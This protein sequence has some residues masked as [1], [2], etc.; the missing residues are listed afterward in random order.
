M[1]QPVDAF[2]ERIPKPFVFALGIALVMTIG[3]IDLLSAPARHFAFLYLGPIALVSWY[4]GG[5]AGSGIALLS[6]L[7]GFL[8]AFT[9]RGIPGSWEELLVSGGVFFLE[10]IAVAQLR[11]KL[12]NL[13]RMATLDALTGLPNA[14]AFFE[15]MTRQTQQCRGQNPLTLVYV[16]LGGVDRVNRSL[17]HAAGDQLLCTMAQVIKQN[18]PRPELIGRVGGTTF[19]LLLPNAGAES[20]KATVRQLQT[21]LYEARRKS[22]LAITFSISAMTCTEAPPSVAGLM[23][24]AESRLRRS[25]ARH[26][27][28]LNIVQID[29]FSALH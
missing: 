29:S 7:Y 8:P 19:A 28:A 11:R 4:V 3:G 1:M 2:L 25:K 24:E 21:R 9:S 13:S 6:L 14:L 23:R 26:H 18:L 12:A 16:D 27:D 10:A 5:M 20:V 15:L 17:G 22:L